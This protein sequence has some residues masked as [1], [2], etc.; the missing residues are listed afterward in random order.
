MALAAAAIPLRLDPEEDFRPWFLIRGSS[1]VPVEPEHSKWDLG[2]TTGRY[3]ESLLHARQMGVRSAS[4]SQAEERLQRYLFQLLGPDGR[5]CDPATG[6]PDHSFAQG[7]AMSGLLALYEDSADPVVRNALERLITAQL[8][9]T[10]RAGDMLVDRSV[11]LD[12]AT[13]SHLAGCQIYP[14]ARFHEL[15]GFGDALTL[16]R[17][18]AQWVINDPVVTTNGEITKPLSWEGNIS[19]WLESWAGCAY[20][21]RT[22]QITNSVE[23][24]NRAEAVYDWVLRNQATTFGWVATY[25]TGGSS[26]TCAISS[27]IR[28]ALELAAAGR[29]RCFDDVERFTRNQLLAAQFTDLKS[30]AK[31]DLEPTPLLLG[32]FD[33][34]SMPD[35]HLGTRGGA[36]VGTVEGCCL[37]GGTRGLWLAWNAMVVADEK[38]VT[39]HLPFTRNHPAADVV[40]YQ[41]RE[42]RLD[43]TPR[44]S[45]AVRF[46]FPSTVSPNDI[47][48]AINR[49]KTRPHFED[50]YV[51]VEAV[52]AGS[53]VSF[54]FPLPERQENI[55]VAGQAYEVRWRGNTVTSVRTNGTAGSDFV[56]AGR[57]LKLPEHLPFSDL[58]PDTFVLN[59]ACELAAKSMLARM[60]LQRR[61]QPFFSLHPFASPPSAEHEKWDDGDMSG[62]YV[63]ALI[64]SR[65]L[66]GLPM[67]QREPLLRSYLV[68]LFDLS[69]GLCYTQ[70]TEWTPRRVCLFSQSSVM[71]GLLSWH[72]ETG[73][74]EARTLLD[75]QCD[76]LMRLAVRTNDCAF[77]PKYEFDGHQWIN[78]PP[79]RNAPPWYG[80]RLIVPL[81]EYWKLTGRNDVRKFI[82]ELTRYCVEVSDFIGSNGEVQTGPGRWGQLHGTM[83]M[84]AGIAEFGHCTDHP[85]WVQWAKRIYDWIGRTQT[86]RDGWVADVSGGSHG[87][88]CGIASRIRLGLA[89]YRAGVADPFGEIDRHLR[90]HLLEAQIK[91]LPPSRE[92]TP[93][94]ARS[95]KITYEGI[96]RMLRGSFQRTSTANDLIGSDEVEGCG[97]GGGAQ[98]IALALAAQS[99]WHDYDGGSELRIHLLFNGTFRAKPVH[100]FTRAAP[101]AAELQTELPYN[102]RTLVLAHE[103]LD[104]LAI[105]LPDGAATNTVRVRR[106]A[107]CFGPASLHVRKWREDA[108]QLAQCYVLVDRVLPGEQIELL[109]DLERYETVEVAAGVEYRMQWKGSSVVGIQP[110]GTRVPLY[111]GRDKLIKSPTPASG[112]RYP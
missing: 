24:L 18:L 83:D 112:P 82:E 64:L 17:G 34:Q 57:P 62:R 13:G 29:T 3:L 14:A 86:T 107:P 67:D 104:R 51:S 95:D 58:V 36:D 106:L 54:R 100:P 6:E 72:S 97:A 110:P 21:A 19:S 73:S 33:S 40:D 49:S 50:G 94:T 75:W 9:N 105:R 48:V 91:D 98:A 15:T 69:D 20:L 56:P 7:S 96:D 88:V 55:A 111:Q 74:M 66:T 87:D 90:N 93:Q 59:D 92:V 79:D 1:G 42:G 85:E 4:L 22:H 61:G 31:E 43:V 5:I 45:G 23:I 76:G 109:F 10:E 38:G 47:T 101:I 53:T 32:G 16:A 103:L 77:F 11:K 2:D 80:G 28:L 44:S 84:A 70:G 60:D 65:H 27:A 37:H 35:R 8:K 99:D 78:D 102:G 46:R 68:S 108:T 81:V 89:L 52:P 25:P 39:V 71:L 63:E 26:E 30:L 12:E 41:P